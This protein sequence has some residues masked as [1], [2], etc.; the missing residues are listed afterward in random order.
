MPAHYEGVGSDKQFYQTG[1]GGWIVGA[2]RGVKVGVVASR[3]GPGDGLAPV[4]LHW[5]TRSYSGGEGGTST[6][7]AT[8]AVVFTGTNRVHI[9]THTL[10]W[11]HCLHFEFD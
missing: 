1:L 3:G 5:V 8:A 10:A 7:R 11:Q 9:D 6:I 2:E 4:V